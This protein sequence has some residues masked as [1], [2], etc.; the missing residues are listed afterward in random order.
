MACCYWSDGLL[1]GWKSIK[2]PVKSIKEEGLFHSPSSHTDLRSQYVRM[3]KSINRFPFLQQEKL[4]LPIPSFLRW[5]PQIHCL[6]S[7]LI[8]CLIWDRVRREVYDLL[9]PLKGTAGSSIYFFVCITVI[10]NS[11]NLSAVFIRKLQNKVWLGDQ[12]VWILSFHSIWMHK[13][14]DLNALILH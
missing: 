4:K 3:A 7:F 9:W 10:V 13:K 5:N 12:P 6:R 8:S 11:W 1:L 2:L 14:P